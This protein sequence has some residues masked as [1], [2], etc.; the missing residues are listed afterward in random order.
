MGEVGQA[1]LGTSGSFSHGHP[2]TAPRI[3][4]EEQGE[5]VPVWGW[6]M[7]LSPREWPG[8]P[9]VASE[10][11]QTHSRR[12]L[13]SQPT[14]YRTPRYQRP[15]LVLKGCLSSSG[16]LSGTPGPGTPSRS[17][18]PPSTE[19]C[20]GCS[21]GVERTG[22]GPEGQLVVPAMPSVNPDRIIP[23]EQP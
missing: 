11:N 4:R 5:Q 1:D 14:W 21:S 23:K 16:A 10:C 3:R 9:S 2:Y 6:E 7:L 12:N 20:R 8:G 17:D 15:F 13:D 22:Q 18:H 19:P